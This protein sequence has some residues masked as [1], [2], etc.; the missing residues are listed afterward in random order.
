MHLSRVPTTFS[1]I[2]LKMALS[3][4]VLLLTLPAFSNDIL[5]ILASGYSTPA[6]SLGRT[7][8][9]AALKAFSSFGVL[10]EMKASGVKSRL[11]KSCVSGGTV[12]HFGTHQKIIVGLVSLQGVTIPMATLARRKVAP[13]DAAI[14]GIVR[15]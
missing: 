5:C 6:P 4:R 13:L 1:E 10:T 11:V 14:N 9:T 3:D 8:V 2:L 15:P 7:W 12:I